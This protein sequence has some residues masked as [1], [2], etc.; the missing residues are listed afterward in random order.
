[1]RTPALEALVRDPSVVESVP[2]DEIPALLGEVEE[3][4]GKLM[5]RLF[6]S[7]VQPV[8][9]ATPTPGD[10]GPDK[11]LTAKE[12]SE[13]LGVTTKWVYE[14][15]KRLPFA[16]RLSPGTLRFSEKALRRWM[17]SRGS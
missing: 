15:S 14:R 5:L 6:S 13:I 16:R 10:G 3:L 11:L 2:A 1:M 9:T 17:S 12:A 8:Q 7:G 4:K